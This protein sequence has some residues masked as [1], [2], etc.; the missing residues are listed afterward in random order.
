MPAA[1]ATQDPAAGLEVRAFNPRTKSVGQPPHGKPVV[2]QVVQEV[3]D[4]PHRISQCGRLLLHDRRNPSGGEVDQVEHELVGALGLDVETFQRSGREVAEV[5]GHDDLRATSDR[6]GEHVSVVRIGQ[7]EAVDQRLVAGDEAVGDGLAHQLPR[8]RQTL[9]VQI[10]AAAQD[11]AHHLVED[12][13]RPARSEMPGLPEPDEQV[14]QSRR[15]QDVG[16]VEGG[17]GH[18]RPVFQS[19]RPSSSAWRVSSSRTS[20]RRASS[21]RL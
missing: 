1:R 7:R 19:Y 21:C 3:L 6:R 9:L 2:T 8:P 4:G 15:V 10:R 17:E 18:R 11:A 16:A 12:L 14:A 20:W 13:L 5:C